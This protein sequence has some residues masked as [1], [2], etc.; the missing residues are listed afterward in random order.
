M[1]SYAAWE[2][3]D[4]EKVMQQMEEEEKK[5]RQQS[6]AQDY[7][8]K[9]VHVVAD[10]GDSAEVLATKAAL[11]AL[12]AKKAA[13]RAP[14][15]GPSPPTSFNKVQE[16]ER[17]ASLLQRKSVAIQTAMTA[18][19]K[20]DALLKKNH[21]AAAIDEYKHVL[22]AMDDLDAIIPQ[23]QLSEEVFEA[24]KPAE[25]DV[26]TDHHDCS[27][28]EP[29]KAAPVV[30]QPLPKS[31]DLKGIAH[32]LRI[33]ALL[34]LGKCELERCHFGAAS[35]HLK[36]A[37]LQDGNHLEAWRL[38]GTAF[39]SMGATLIGMLH[40]N[41]VVLMEGSDSG[42][43]SKQLAE[44]EDELVQD[45]VSED[46]VYTAAM[47]YLQRPTH[48][49]TIERMVLLR[50]E[51]D[52]IM[53]E[54]FYAYSNQ[55]Y[56]AI[57]DTLE[58]LPWSHPALL[59]LRCA[60]H[61]SI[62]GGLFEM[63]KQFP[64]AIRHCEAVLTHQ[65]L[66]TAMIYRLGQCYRQTNQFELAATMLQRALAS[67]EPASPGQRLVLDELERNAFDRSELDIEYIKRVEG[68]SSEP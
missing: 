36:L 43:G 58:A 49:E 19:G 29:E 39:M 26:C 45:C 52:V 33:D 21:A 34:G 55:K 10:A 47:Q 44:V 5:E 17:Q 54:G 8:K 28:H 9:K 32:M 14:S 50:E 46:E 67:L 57:L 35:E 23:L 20:A 66:H 31:S 68:Q 40:L 18:R 51:A 22:S 60:C 15:A 38:R 42:D 13:A 6:Q 30:V 2:K 12:K 24:N 3:Y 65:P 11:A 56:Q 59:D 61:A 53:L 37:L 16:L 7:E 62:A 1:T 63:K 48:K 27:C 25:K 41:K 4:V 64:L